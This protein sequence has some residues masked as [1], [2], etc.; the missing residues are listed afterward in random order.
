MAGLGRPGVV[1]GLGREGGWLRQ[2]LPDGPSVCV[3]GGF[4]HPHPVPVPSLSPCR[5]LRP[6]PAP[7]ASTHCLS[8][9][10]PLQIPSAPSILRR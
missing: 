6:Q 1:T 5:S 7:G 4:P 8:P 9:L 10:T 2:A 3:W